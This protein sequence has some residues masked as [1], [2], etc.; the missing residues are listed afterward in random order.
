MKKTAIIP[1]IL[2]LGIGLFTVKLAV[3]TI[4]KAQA[5]NAPTTMMTVVQAREDID[6]FETI[7]AE[8][9]TLLETAESDLAPE[10][11]RIETLEDVVG[12]VTAK[13]IPARV[14]VLTSMLAPPGT[15]PGLLGKIEPGFR[16]VSVKIDEVTAVA[17]QIKPG[18]WVDVHVVMDVDSGRRGKKET[19]AKL[20]LEHVQVASIGRNSNAQAAAGGPVKSKPAKSATLLVR[21]EDVAKLHLVATRGKLALALRGEDD[22]S[23]DGTGG[24]AS[25]DE[26]FGGKRPTQHVT[27]QDGS[28]WAQMGSMFGAKGQPEPAPVVLASGRVEDDP[29]T[30]LVVHGWAGGDPAQLPVIGRYTFESPDSPMLIDS[31]V[32]LPMGVDATLSRGDRKS[33]ASGGEKTQ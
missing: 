13:A 17:Y 4:R 32:G 8:M 12:R 21:E 33:S 11:E 7:T 23:T 27:G 24:M 1:L 14:P 9:L 15:P 22:L 5:A 16:A 2:G 20:V 31:R 6:A 18:D 26:V 3:D 28:F 10:D 25:F 19:I 29:R 30:V